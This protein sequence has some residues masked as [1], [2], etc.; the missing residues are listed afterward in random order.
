MTHTTLPGPVDALKK[1]AMKAAVESKHSRDAYEEL[2][3]TLSPQQTAAWLQ[4]ERESLQEG[5]EGKSVYDIR[6]EQGEPCMTRRRAFIDCPLAPGV[7]E[8]ALAVAQRYEAEDSDEP[9]GLELLREA[10]RIESVQ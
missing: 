6:E 4:E 3:D 2:R 8:R 5:R 7:A 1:K 10:M 9:I